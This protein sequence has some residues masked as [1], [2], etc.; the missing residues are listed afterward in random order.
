MTTFVVKSQ[1]TNAQ[2]EGGFEVFVEKLLTEV[3]VPKELHEN[4]ET[5]IRISIDSLGTAKLLTIKPYNKDFFLN[6]QKFVA[7]SKWIAAIENGIAKKSMIQLPLVFEQSQQDI[8]K[9]AE[10][11]PKNGLAE[12]YKYFAQKLNLKTYK[13]NTLVCDAKF[14]VLEDGSLELISISEN[15]AQLYNELKE[16]FTKAEK[17]N[18]AIKDGKTISSIKNFK[19]TIKK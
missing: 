8:Q 14:K 2:P 10:A 4:K 17:W 16:L 13:E 7:E 12:F 1:N 9:N 15:N 11:S 3:S 19:L 6:V 18:P 5:I